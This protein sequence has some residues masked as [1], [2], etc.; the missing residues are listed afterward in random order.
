MFLFLKTFINCIG[1]TYNIVKGLGV[2][3]ISQV[4]G[5]LEVYF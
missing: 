2:M 5:A 4:E 1:V 3:E